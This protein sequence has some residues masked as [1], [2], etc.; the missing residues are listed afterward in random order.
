DNIHYAEVLYFFSRHICQEV[1]ALAMV[2]LYSLPDPTLEKDSSG[3][4]SVC[5]SLGKSSIMVIDATTIE[6][7][8]GMIPFPLQNSEKNQPET[9]NR[10]FNTFY[11]AEKPCTGISIAELSEIEQEESAEQPEQEEDYDEE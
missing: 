1:R 10:Y 11:V 8:V 3:T 5:Q 7:V 6:L 4:L 9:S 2:S